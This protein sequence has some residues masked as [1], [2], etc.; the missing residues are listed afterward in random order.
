MPA[1]CTG[2]DTVYP[3][4]STWT[5]N[6]KVVKGTFIIKYLMSSNVTWKSGG[7]LAS[8]RGPTELRH[9]FEVG[10]NSGVT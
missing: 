1:K 6:I 2:T 4:D 7:T 8:L 10:Q 5:R 3:S 9:H